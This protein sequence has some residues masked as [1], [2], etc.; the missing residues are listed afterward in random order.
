MR[1]LQDP[2][3]PEETVTSR[4]LE[5]GSDDN[6]KGLSTGA[7]AGIIA[8]VAAMTLLLGACAIFF[9]VGSR[10]RRKERWS[11]EAWDAHAK[12]RTLTKAALQRPPSGANSANN[13]EVSTV[14]AGGWINPHF[15]TALPPADALPLE[16]KAAGLGQAAQVPWVH[17]IN[18]PGFVPPYSHSQH[19]AQNAEALQVGAMSP[20]P[21]QWLPP[22]ALPGSPAAQYGAAQ[23]GNGIG[24]PQSLLPL[25]PG[26]G[27][28][29]PTGP[30]HASATAGGTRV[31]TVGTESPL[32]SDRA[33]RGN[34]PLGVQSMGSETYKERMQEFAGS[35]AGAYQGCSTVFTALSFSIVASATGKDVAISSLCIHSFSVLLGVSSCLGIVEF[36][37]A[38]NRHTQMNH[39]VACNMGFG[40]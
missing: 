4:D 7:L 12:Q 14:A 11:E 28:T 32:S 3:T 35:A 30:S 37:R 26:F 20:Q 13:S 27:P 31:G 23:H 33:P 8:A 18:G 5:D 19:G 6:K 17:A 36:C 40:E 15:N 34:Q 10:R 21:Y 16:Y 29:G 1:H 38:W 24:S 39:A 22:A 2:E 25:P 9:I